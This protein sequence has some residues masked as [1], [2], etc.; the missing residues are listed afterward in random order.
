MRNTNQK[1]TKSQ[2]AYFEQKE[3]SNTQ[4]KAIRIMWIAVGTLAG[5]LAFTLGLG[6]VFG[7]LT[8]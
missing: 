6:Y 3:A 4:M 2:V 1:A 5:A 8:K 7:Y